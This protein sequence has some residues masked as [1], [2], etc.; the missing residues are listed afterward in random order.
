MRICIYYKSSQR[1]WGGSNSFLMALR[2]FFSKVEDVEIVD[3]INGDYDILLINSAYRAPGMYFNYRHIKSVK[4]YG[5][6]AWAFYLL[7]RFKRKNKILVHRLDG[8]RSRYAEVMTRMDDIQWK[9]LSIADYAIFQSRYSYELF[10]YHGFQRERFDII[11]NGVDQDIFNMDNKV[12]WNKNE[13]LRLVSSSWS[14]NPAK[15]HEIIARISELKYIDVVFVGRWAE[16]INPKCVKI[17]PPQTQSK[18]ADIYKRSHIYLFPSQNESCPNSVLE[19]LSCGLPV[20]YYDNAGT[21]EIAN[22]YGI[23]LT[24]NLEDNINSISDKYEYFVERIRKNVSN[25]SIEYAGGNYL[26]VF[27]NLFNE[28]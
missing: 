10:R 22:G 2:K 8:I 13:R 25:F 19:A 9:S 6:T 23:S 11:Y 20:L 18:L 14:P 12:F 16:G 28:K 5:Y 21:S 15:G 27:K 26:R 7:S 3:N 24:Q 17:I 4:K 1:P